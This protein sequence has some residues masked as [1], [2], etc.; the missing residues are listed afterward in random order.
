V[1][2]QNGEIPRCCDELPNTTK[3]ERWKRAA[4]EVITPLTS[5]LVEACPQDQKNIG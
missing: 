1:V 5:T 4:E 3:L 2:A